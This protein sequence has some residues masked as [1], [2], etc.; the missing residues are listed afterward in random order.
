MALSSQV[1]LFDGP[2][3]PT[4]PAADA[5]A[6]TP[7]VA[8]GAAAEPVSRPA[9]MA[10]SWVPTQVA[11]PSREAPP[12]RRWNDVAA[13]EDADEDGGASAP[14]IP[15]RETM[16]HL[17]QQAAAAALRVLLPGGTPLP[18]VSTTST[19]S[20]GLGGPAGGP[21][22]V[23]G[24]TVIVME[25]QPL[26][27]STTATT[28]TATSASAAAAAAPAAPTNAAGRRADSDRR[29]EPASL[30]PQPGQPVGR[31]ESVSVLEP[32]NETQPPAPG[33]GSSPNALGRRAAPVNIP[34]LQSKADFRLVYIASQD[35]QLVDARAVAAAAAPPSEPV[36]QPA[37]PPLLPSLPPLPTPVRPVQPQQQAQPPAAEDEDVVIVASMAETS[38]QEDDMVDRQKPSPVVQEVHEADGAHGV[39]DVH[40]VHE[41]EVVDSQPVRRVGRASSGSGAVALAGR[42]RLVRMHPFSA[43]PPRKNVADLPVTSRPVVRWDGSARRATQKTTSP[44][45]SRLPYGPA[46]PRLP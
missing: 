34:V 38:G 31:H 22:A 21:G 26:L 39:H 36:V 14:H 40:E 46:Q 25:S 42:R 17:Q 37:S 30:A 24:A 20:T 18:Q 15:S 23:A 19:S 13:D 8:E 27:P 11:S 33:G 29:S 41:D 43:L 4:T 32:E 9:V 16:N 6:T 44:A 12:L 5:D 2:G 7:D 28:T 10:S 3:G 45:Q 35:S 1:A